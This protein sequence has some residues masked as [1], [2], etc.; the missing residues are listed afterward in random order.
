MKALINLTTFLV[1][2]DQPNYTPNLG[3]CKLQLEDR[4]KYGVI[5]VEATQKNKNV[6]FGNERRHELKIIIEDDEQV[7]FDDTFSALIEKLK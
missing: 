6:S 1:L 5:R 3:K 7:I 4:K 2:T